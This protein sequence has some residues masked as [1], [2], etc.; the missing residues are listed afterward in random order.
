MPKHCMT[1]LR[2][3]AS[4][5]SA[6]NAL[7]WGFSVCAT[8]LM[9]ASPP[10]VGSPVTYN[11]A[12]TKP[13]ATKVLTDRVREGVCGNS[14]TTSSFVSLRRQS[15]RHRRQRTCDQ[16]LYTAGELKCLP[17]VP[18]V[19]GSA[20]REWLVYLA[21]CCLTM[22]FL[23]C[24][25][26]RLRHAGRYLSRY[27]HPCRTVST[28][29]QVTYRQKLSLPRFQS[30]IRIS[31]RR[32]PK[33]QDSFENDD[34][35]E[36]CAVHVSSMLPRHSSTLSPCSCARSVSNA[37]ANVCYPRASFQVHVVCH[38]MPAVTS[39]RLLER[40]RSWCWVVVFAALVYFGFEDQADRSEHSLGG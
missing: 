2:E 19:C 15:R 33:N 28:L 30:H 32:E 12:M 39:L 23:L 31:R 17:N 21:E 34:Q 24:F 18:F 40:C 38:R 22:L 20:C 29:S 25:G 6:T 14:F 1:L 36:I 16:P 10:C 13:T 9:P 3:M 26:S 27:E 11:S 7:A 5:A 35:C 8:D 37:S 4:Q